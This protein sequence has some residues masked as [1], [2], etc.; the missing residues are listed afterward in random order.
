M[1]ALIVKF[2]NIYKIHTIYPK[3]D[4]LD[5]DEEENLFIKKTL[6]L[7]KTWTD[8]VQLMALI[9]LIHCSVN[10]HIVVFFSDKMCA[11]MY[12]I[13][14]G[15]YA[16]IDGDEP[17]LRCFDKRIFKLEKSK[18][19]KQLATFLYLRDHHNITGYII[20]TIDKDLASILVRSREDD[21]IK[22][23]FGNKI[24]ASM[25]RLDLLYV[26]MLELKDDFFNNKSDEMKKNIQ[27]EYQKMFSFFHDDPSFH[28][29]ISS[30]PDSVAEF[31]KTHANISKEISSWND[32]YI[33]LLTLSID[34]YKVLEI[35]HNNNSQIYTYSNLLDNGNAVHLRK[36]QLVIFKYIY[37]EFGLETISLIGDLET[38]TRFPINVL[39]LYTDLV[40]FVVKLICSKIKSV[41]ENIYTTDVNDTIYEDYISTL[42][43]IIMPESKRQRSRIDITKII[44]KIMSDDNVII[45]EVLQNI[46][47]Y[48]TNIDVSGGLHARL[49]LE[50]KIQR[51][52]ENYFGGNRGS[53][54]KHNRRKKIDTRKRQRKHKH[55]SRK[56]SH[57]AIRTSKARPASR[58][59]R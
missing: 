49:N 51:R 7:I 8:S 20:P 27:K 43:T 24:P 23:L 5:L 40:Y 47:L 15:G 37:N 1:P 13:L 14:G 32:I 21:P 17:S 39:K 44:D 11:T 58:R 34:L 35:I 50:R 48:N 25:K 42:F 41:L 18:L 28:N 33:N 3:S 45:E 36:E 55:K 31:Y 6:T 16:F 22:K 19:A 59:F 53:R 56:H 46:T 12:R 9:Q 52:I 38:R 4:D 2:R 57:A 26:Y 10:S 29:Y 30:F 54:K